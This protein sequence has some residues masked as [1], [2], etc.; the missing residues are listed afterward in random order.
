MLKFVFQMKVTGL[1]RSE[2]K[3]ATHSPTLAKRRAL[4]PDRL[5]SYDPFDKSPTLAKHFHKSCSQ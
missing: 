2:V 1:E 3:E 5:S 4:F